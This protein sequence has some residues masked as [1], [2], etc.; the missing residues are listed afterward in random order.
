MPV[1]LP[2]ASGAAPRAAPAS[3]AGLAGWEPAAGTALPHSTEWVFNRVPI[4]D[5]QYAEHVAELK[6]EQWRR[7]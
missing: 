2:I 1:L 7:E 5:T 4:A 3:Q 6:W